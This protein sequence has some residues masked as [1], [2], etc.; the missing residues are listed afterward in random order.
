NLGEVEARLRRVPANAPETL[1]EAAQCLLLM[2]S[3]LHLTGEIVPL[4]R[5][6]QLLGRFYEEDRK[7]GRLGANDKEAARRGQEVID[8]LWVKL[9]S[10]V[11]L[12]NRHA[13]DRFTPSD[14]ALLGNKGASNFD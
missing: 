2:H 3:V 4:G 14:G 6:D 11:I 10:N 8:L 1:V 9:N 7:A 12:D 13:V 5:V